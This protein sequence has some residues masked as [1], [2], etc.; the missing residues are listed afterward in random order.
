MTLCTS[1]RGM[2]L[3]HLCA[4]TRKNMFEMTVRDMKRGQGLRT[5]RGRD[6]PFGKQPSQP[7]FSIGHDAHRRPIVPTEAFAIERRRVPKPPPRGSDHMLSEIKQGPGPRRIK[8]LIT[9][10]MQANTFGETAN[11]RH[12]HARPMP[13]IIKQDP[14]DEPGPAD[15]LLK[16][17]MKTRKKTTK[18]KRG[19]GLYELAAAQLAPLLARQ[20]AGF[21]RKRKR[22]GPVGR[23]MV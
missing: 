22:G 21:S 20:F 23:P 6:E 8:K 9:S 14:D 19:S 10:A 11:F 13:G 2:G 7:A 5:R 4:P 16:Q 12:P 15:R 17:V 3:E 1:F 18:R